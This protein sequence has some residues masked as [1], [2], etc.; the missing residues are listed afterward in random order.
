MVAEKEAN[1]FILQPKLRVVEFFSLSVDLKGFGTQLV[2]LK[3]LH[4]FNEVSP[5]SSNYDEKYRGEKFFSL[6]LKPKKS[7]ESKIETENLQKR[8]SHAHLC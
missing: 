3:S 5:L 1:N 6:F 8:G 2:I 7:E 4:Y